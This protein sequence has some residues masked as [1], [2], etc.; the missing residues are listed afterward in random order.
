MTTD[1]DKAN[2]LRRQWQEDP[3]S[4]CR[5][6]GWPTWADAIAEH[7]LDCEDKQATILE[8]LAGYG[9]QQVWV[10]SGNAV[11]KSHA[12][13]MA[14]GWFL[15]AF[16]PC[17]VITT[18][19]T[20]RQVSI[21]WKQ[22]H[23]L[24]GKMPLPLGGE[25]LQHEWKGPTT[26]W[27]AMGFTSAPHDPNRFQG[28][29]AE[30]ILVVI[31]EANGVGEWVWEG[32]RGMTMTPNAKTL[33]IGNPHIPEGG[34][35]NAF[36]ED[37]KEAGSRGVCIHIDSR[38]T[39]NM[40]A[41]QSVIMGLATEK[42]IDELI[43]DYGVDSP[44]VQARVYGEFPSDAPDQLIKLS[45]IQAAVDRT[46][47][48]FGNKEIGIDVGGDGDNADETVFAEREGD[49]IGQLQIH[50]KHDT[51]EVANYAQTWMRE[52]GAN[53]LKIDSIGVGKGV[54]DT[55]T[56]RGIDRVYSIQVGEAASDPSRF[57][58]L[59]SEY[60]W[61]LRERFEQG[62]IDIPND[63]TLIAQLASV[64]WKPDNRGRVVVERKDEMRKRGL[65]SPDRAE[66]V[67]MAFA[68]VDDLA[69]FDFASLFV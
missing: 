6:A 57:P 55:L 3:L 41:G 31:D 7:G 44:V 38:Y 26:N 40:V 1:L 27:F 67:L 50:H 49:T 60:W 53:T 9:R 11:G 45:W 36:E 63:T 64:K 52:I 62:R 61:K 58:N 25:M 39:P 32:I 15:I 8:A 12:A 42:G 10:R 66:A 22:L 20:D 34:F 14:A 23:A 59:R 46:L 17:I 47:E 33:S 19:P 43:Q 69:D 2:A 30:N 68:E 29:N 35:F 51:V 5:W 54:L 18:A 28:F 37:K 13:A 16:A 4:F 21:L 65:R 24:L 48:R 56:H